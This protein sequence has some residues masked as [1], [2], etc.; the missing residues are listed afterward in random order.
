M[1][2]FYIISG[3]GSKGVS[4]AVLSFPH[5]KSLKAVPPDVP[6]SPPSCCGVT[7]NKTRMMGLAVCI[8]V[9]WGEVG[10]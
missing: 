10:R 5:G 2:L 1:G 8:S 3:S 4:L 7:V 9:F 6:M